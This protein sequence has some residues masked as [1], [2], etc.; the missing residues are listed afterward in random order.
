MITKNYI[1]MCEQAEEIQKVCK[2]VAGDWFYS[3]K[4]NQY[5]I[6][7]HI[8][9]GWKHY[10][11][12]TWLPT[13]EQLQEMILPV[14]KI[15]YNKYWKLNKMKRL[16]NWVF[17]IFFRF[18]KENIQDSENRPIC[19][20]SNNMNELWLAFVMYEKYQKIWTGEKWVKA[21]G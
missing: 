9:E 18:I 5:Y 1:K 21:N 15:K 14:L 12:L 20:H 7:N 8:G 11:D 10:I 17:G 16:A 2:N 4:L 19:N 6:N 13:Q 3:I